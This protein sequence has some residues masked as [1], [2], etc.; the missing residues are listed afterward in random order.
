LRLRR[1]KE[2]ASASRVSFRRQASTIFGKPDSVNHSQFFETIDYAISHHAEQDHSGTITAVLARYPE[3][4]VICS[5]KAKGILTVSKGFGE[6]LARK[7]QLDRKLMP[8]DRESDL[9]IAKPGLRILRKR[10]NQDEKEH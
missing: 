5:S 4:V 7:L 8:S 9:C 3:A 10:G 2:E 1:R 6:I